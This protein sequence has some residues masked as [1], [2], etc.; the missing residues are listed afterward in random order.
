MIPISGTAGGTNE[1]YSRFNLDSTSIEK[2][3]I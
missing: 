1:D 3:P 2:R